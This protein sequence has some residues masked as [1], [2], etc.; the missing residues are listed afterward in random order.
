MNVGKIVLVVCM[1]LAGLSTARAGSITLSQNSYS[2]SDGGEFTAV[3][4][5]SISLSNY[6]P[7]RSLVKDLKHS[8]SNRPW[9]FLPALLIPMC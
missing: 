2:F 9:N 5:P 3:T 1:L 7:K 4:S 8:A 6:A